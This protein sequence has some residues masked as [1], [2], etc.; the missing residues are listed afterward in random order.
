MVY[1]FKELGMGIILIEN[2]VYE[3]QRGFFVEGYNREAFAENG[4]ENDFMQYVFSRSKKGV[5]RGL[6][7][8]KDPYSQ[9]KLLRV[10]R[11]EIFDVSVDIRPMSPTFGK[12]VEIT[13]KGDGH[14]MIYIPRNFAHGFVAL[15]DSDVL[16]YVDNRYAQKQEGGILWNDPEL[17]IKYPIQ[18]TLMSK[19][20]AIWKPL[21]QTYLGI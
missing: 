10:I 1:V 14:Q 3:D 11:G 20:D 8:Q 7:F 6:H 16:Y 13:L 19:K 17:D 12:H 21:S 2:E 15:E 4:I 5:F 18:P 9:A